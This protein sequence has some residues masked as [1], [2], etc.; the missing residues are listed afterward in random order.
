[1]E[2]ASLQITNWLVQR[3]STEH[4]MI[5][6]AGSGNNGG[7]VLAIARQMADLDFICEVNLLD[8]GKG[9]EGSPAINWQRLE[10]QGKVKLS[11]IGN[12]SDFPKIDETDV[13]IDGLFGSGLT[14]PL[15]GLAGEI[16]KKINGLSSPDP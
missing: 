15:E 8:F 16:V 2:R 7:D 6:F 13:I 9:L 5:F 10:E 11:K 3:F 12:I 1:M 4:K 14:R